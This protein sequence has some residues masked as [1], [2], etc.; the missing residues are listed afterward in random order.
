MARRLRVLRRYC[1][2]ISIHHAIHETMSSLVAESTV[3]SAARTAGGSTI[4]SIRQTTVKTHFPLGMDFIINISLGFTGALAAEL[5]DRRRMQPKRTEVCRAGQNNLRHQRSRLLLLPR[6][7]AM[8]C[9]SVFSA[10]MRLGGQ[11]LWTLVISSF[12]ISRWKTA[13]MINATSE[14]Q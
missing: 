7:R 5:S 4:F 8:L 6:R 11:R 10:D 13:P 2:H 1:R 9:P 14:A 12:N 3:I